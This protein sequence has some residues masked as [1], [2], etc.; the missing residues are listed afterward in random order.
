MADGRSLNGFPLK[1]VGGNS[2]KRMDVR[3]VKMIQDVARRFVSMTMAMLNPLII[4]A[5]Q[6]NI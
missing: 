5:R 4:L 3:S 1:E 6:T 2:R